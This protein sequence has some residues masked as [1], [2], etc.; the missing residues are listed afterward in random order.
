MFLDEDFYSYMLSIPHE[1]KK[2]RELYFKWIEKYLPDHF[3]YENTFRFGCKPKQKSKYL[4]YRL[5]HGVM[6]RLG[7][8]TKHDMNPFME[9][10]RSNP[11]LVKEQDEAFKNDISIL[12]NSSINKL[13]VEKLKEELEKL[14]FDKDLIN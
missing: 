8:K 11:I 14:N 1:I 3:K 5:Y 7:F 12:E 13:I 9:W 6:N 10:C 2:N 4:C